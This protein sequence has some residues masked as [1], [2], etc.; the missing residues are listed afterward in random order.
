MN[1]R[2]YFSRPGKG[3]FLVIRRKN[4]VHKVWEVKVNS[5]FFFVDNVNSYY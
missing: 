3:R 4:T 5:F 1:Y 2:I